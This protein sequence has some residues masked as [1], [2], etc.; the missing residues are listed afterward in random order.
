MT[1]PENNDLISK[2]LHIS[3]L[4]PAI[5]FDD[6]S[7]RLGSFGSVTVVDGLGK[8][9]G[10]GQPRKFAYVTLQT[11]KPQLSRCMNLLSGST[12]KGAKLRIG[13]AKPDFRERII[14][15][16]APKSSDDTHQR[17][18]RRLTR[19]VLGR[20]AQDM[21]LIT[22]DNVHQRPQWRV[23]PLGRLIR[24]MRMRPA[25]P[26]DPPI[27]P[28]RTKNVEKGTRK[29]KKRPRPPPT[30]ARRQTIDP[31]RWGST[32]LS[33]IFLDGNENAPPP[34]R[35]GPDGDG[36][37]KG[38][39]TEVD[40]VENILEV[41]DQ[42]PTGD[43]SDDKMPP[44]ASDAELDLAAE[45]ASALDLL[46]SMFGEANTDW[47]GAESV[48]SDL[49]VEMAGIPR[50]PSGPLEPTD[51]EV[52][53]AAH[54]PRA[55]PREEKNT[56]VD[57]PAGATPTP[58][59]TGP[60]QS[61]TQNKLKD[62]FAP[63]EEEGFSLIGHLD[64]DSELDLEFD[65]DLNLD[66]PVFPNVAA[67]DPVATS[68]RSVLSPALL[69]MQHKAL[70]S[71][72]PFF[73]PREGHVQRVRFVRTED[74]TEIRARWEAARGELTREWKR[75]HREAVKSRRRRGGERVE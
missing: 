48:D 23:T 24:P 6:L 66:E 49:D 75:R 58:A 51:F 2:R 54:E 33:G 15:E 43:D 10:L 1:M 29:K 50:T 19:G 20:H 47:G 70:H 45:R 63:R 27:D 37:A 41:S 62:L 12:W 9:D 3:G 56:A 31:L 52:V 4:T 46:S 14:L 74:E 32:H 73:F 21:S 8:L 30:R 35:S 11:T 44:R 61:S 26:L 39:S 16:N 55:S 42:T 34:R 13:E 18:R 53:P 25:R 40:E 57:R 7:R 38:E 68:S 28:L 67:P 72:L 69:T 59:T 64:L 17:K 65:M 60:T 22:S 36:S 71:S 5:S